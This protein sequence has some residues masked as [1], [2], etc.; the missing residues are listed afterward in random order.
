VDR[1]RRPQRPERFRRDPRSH[2][3]PLIRQTG[4]NT[5]HPA[6]PVEA[7]PE[8]LVKDELRG[9]VSEL[10]RQ[11]VVELVREQLNGSAAASF[12]SPA[13]A[14]V[15]GP[16][17]A[18]G[19]PRRPGPT[20]K[21]APAER[22]CNRCGETKPA[23]EYARGRGTC[24]SCRRAQQREH[25]RRVALAEDEEP[26]PDDPGPSVDRWLLERGFAEQRDGGLVATAAGRELGAALLD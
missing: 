6:A 18:Q 26:H 15:S 12:R 16:E 21:P 8:A 20:P 22:R 19:A 2:A 24:R 10:V 13:D 23:G 4:A 7:P 5:L 1:D 11:V 3:R 25:D 9:P 17:N 14:A